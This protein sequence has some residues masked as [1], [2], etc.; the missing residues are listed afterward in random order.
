M[1]MKRDL[2][3]GVAPLRA[4]VSS[5]A[6]IHFYSTMN[7]NR[8]R[9][10]FMKTNDLCHFYSTIIWGGLQSLLAVLPPGFSTSVPN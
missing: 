3:T 9:C 2:R 7:M 8:N 1:S 5:Q 6:Q 10:N 4:A